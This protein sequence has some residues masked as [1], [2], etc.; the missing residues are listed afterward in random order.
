MNRRFSIIATIDDKPEEKHSYCE[1][2]KFCR[3][4]NVGEDLICP[5]CGYRKE[6]S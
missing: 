6:T 3:L 5:Q 4:V 1:I 2:H